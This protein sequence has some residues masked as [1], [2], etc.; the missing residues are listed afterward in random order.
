MVFSDDKLTATSR[1]EARIS[2]IVPVRIYGM[3]AN[4]K[5]FGANV[6]TLNISRNGVLLSNVDVALNSG[7]VVGIQKGI[8][9]AKY[10]VKWFGQKGTPTQGQ[11]GLE[12][13]EPAR[14]IFAIEE[15]AV[16]ID[17]NEQAGVKRR[18]GG[19]GGGEKNE[20]RAAA[21]YKCDMGVQVRMEGSEM[22]LWSRCTDV[23]D[24]GCYV[25]SRSPIKVGS[26]LNVTFLFSPI[27]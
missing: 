21:R 26:K 9:K 17:A 6:A 20:R 15:P 16:V 22:N 3:D 10:R 2:A 1:K 23:S 12:C 18:R 24:G 4:G 27:T 25:E 11:V 7:D 13:M 14:N 19:S 5:P 8:A